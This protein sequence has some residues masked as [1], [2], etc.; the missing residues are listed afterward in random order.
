MVVHTHRLKRTQSIWWNKYG[1]TLLNPQPN[2]KPGGPIR[3]MRPW[4]TAHGTETAYFFSMNTKLQWWS[5]KSKHHP[6]CDSSLKQSNVVHAGLTNVSELHLL[7]P[8]AHRVKT[9]LSFGHFYTGRVC[10]GRPNSQNVRRLF[11]CAEQDERVWV[12]IKSAAFV[13]WMQRWEG[14]KWRTE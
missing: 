10:D 8:G 5:V 6:E 7:R 1:G 4:W 14:S 9:L 11:A 2:C 13:L 3:L 12:T